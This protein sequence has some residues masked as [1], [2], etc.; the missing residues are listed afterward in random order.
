[1]IVTGSTRGKCS[2]PQPRGSL[3]LPLTA[4]PQ[5][6]AQPALIDWHAR[7]G[8]CARCG[9]PTAPIKAGWAR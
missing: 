4:P 9:T 1:M 6:R 8:F 2:A 3:S 5:R 7:H